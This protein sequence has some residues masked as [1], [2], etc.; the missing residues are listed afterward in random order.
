MAFRHSPNKIKE[1]H[2]S[3]EIRGRKIPLI[4]RRH[5][6]ARRMILRINMVGE[7]AVITI[8]ANASSVDAL[9]L[10]YDKSSWLCQQLNEIGERVVFGD[11]VQIPFQGVQHLVCHRV[12]THGAVWIEDGEINVAGDIEHLSRRL[13]DW[14]K[15]QAQI[16]IKSLVHQKAKQIDRAPSRVTIRDTRSRWGSCSSK[17][18]LSFSWRLIMAPSEI[19]D[20]VVA[21][22]VAHLA[23]MNHSSRFWNTVDRLTEN[24][25][26]GRAWLNRNGSALH[27]IG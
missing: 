6:R 24:A 11:G 20:Y 3:I 27:R 26:S 25:K 15:K 13:G 10:A 2:H 22:E 9:D 16:R 8:P 4:V 21:H 1:A 7:G 19:L 12:D 17:G 5:P 23:H 14:L 18:G